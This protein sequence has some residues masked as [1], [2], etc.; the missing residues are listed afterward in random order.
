MQMTKSNWKNPAEIPPEDDRDY[1][2]IYKLPDNRYS[3]PHRCYYCKFEK[4][5]FSLE[6]YF[7]HA[8]VVDLYTEMPEV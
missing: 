7:S 2:V 5:F 8:L 1:L 3:S 4:Q 6:A